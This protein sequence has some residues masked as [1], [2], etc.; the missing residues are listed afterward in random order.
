M[1]E[2]SPIISEFSSTE[3][4]EAHDRWFRGKV[5]AALVDPRPSV[6]HDEAMARIRRVIEDEKTKA[7]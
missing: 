6:P 4:A 2:L 5:E 3:E 1:N 7:G